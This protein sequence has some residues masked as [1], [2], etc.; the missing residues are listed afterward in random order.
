MM[1]KYILDLLV[2]M[3]YLFELNIIDVGM[4]SGLSGMFFVIVFLEK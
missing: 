4:G 2:I 1:V 3:F